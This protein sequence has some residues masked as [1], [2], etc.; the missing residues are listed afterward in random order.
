[1]PLS[2]TAVLS[3]VLYVV[4]TNVRDATLI[5]ILTG[6]GIG[7]V[8]DIFYKSFRY[9]AAGLTIIAIV[10]VVVALELV[11]NYVRRAIL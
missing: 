4:E 7:F 9:D 1:M 2:A 3:W 11:S 6:T 10:I 8:F 5:G